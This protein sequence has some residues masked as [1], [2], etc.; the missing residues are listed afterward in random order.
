MPQILLIDE[1]YFQ[2]H[3]QQKYTFVMMNFENKVIVDIIKLKM[4][5]RT[6]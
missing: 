4:A 2:R 6:Q 1:F 5:E 3:S